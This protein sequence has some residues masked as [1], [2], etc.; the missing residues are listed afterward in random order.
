MYEEVPE[1][2]RPWLRPDAYDP[3]AQFL[4]DLEPQSRIEAILKFG[5]LSMVPNAYF[6]D[7]DGKQFYTSDNRPL[8]VNQ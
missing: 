8:V 1:W 4:H 7:S 3:S 2:L 6:Y 5:F